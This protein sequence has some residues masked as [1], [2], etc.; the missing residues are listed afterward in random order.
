M[1]TINRTELLD[2]VVDL[3]LAR[4]K[5]TPWDKIALADLA[6]AADATLA[7]FAAMR[8]TK[9]K[10]THT[11]D[12]RFDRAALATVKG[13]DRSETVRDRLFDAAMRRFDALEGHRGAMMSILLAE[14]SENAAKAARA[15]RRLVTA[16]WLLEAAGIE[17]AGGAGVARAVGLARILRKAEAAWRLD[18]ADLARTMASLDQGLRDAEDFIKRAESFA[19]PDMAA[20]SFDKFG[21][22]LSER[23]SKGFGSRRWP[24]AKGRGKSPEAPPEA[25]EPA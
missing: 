24:F 5:E 21:E 12:R 18:G 10:I 1:T 4:A 15:A 13:V 9:A 6:G 14:D 25:T 8:I 2:K 3:T 19:F 16:A 17:A 20:F 22:K 11:I 7:D 23:F